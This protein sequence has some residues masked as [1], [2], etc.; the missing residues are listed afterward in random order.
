MR[1]AVGP[2]EWT[3]ALLSGLALGSGAAPLHSPRL[4]LA[5]A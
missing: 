1:S 4:P 3:V 5:M 2:W